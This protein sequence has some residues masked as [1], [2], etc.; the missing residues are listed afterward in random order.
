[1]LLSKKNVT[2]RVSVNKTKTYLPPFHIK[3]GLIKISVKAVN[4]QGEGFDYLRLKF[5]FVS[6]AK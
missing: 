5:P 6:E 3:L 1:M 2:L 4:E